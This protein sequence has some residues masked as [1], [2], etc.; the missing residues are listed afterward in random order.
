MKMQSSVWCITC[1]R[2]C[3]TDPGRSVPKQAITHIALRREELC[4]HVRLVHAPVVDR[5]VQRGVDRL[6]RVLVQPQDQ[7]VRLAPVIHQRVG[8]AHGHAVVGER[9]PG[10]PRQRAHPERL[11]VHAVLKHG[12]SLG[13]RARECEAR[14]HALGRQRCG[15]R[16]RQRPLVRPVELPLHR[17]GQRREVIVQARGVK[18]A[19]LRLA[20]QTR[21]HVVLHDLQA[22]PRAVPVRLRGIEEHVRRRVPLLLDEVLAALDQH[23]EQRHPLQ[24]ELRVRRGVALVALAR[25]L[26]IR[27]HPP[28]RLGLQ[29]RV[30][31]RVE[32]DERVVRAVHHAQRAAAP[33]GVLLPGLRRLRRR[34]G[35]PRVPARAL[36]HVLQVYLRRVALR[37]ELRLEDLADP[38]DD[39]G[40][41]RQPGVHQVQERLDLANQHQVEHVLQRGPDL[42]ADPRLVLVRVPRHGL[43]PDRQALPDHAG[44]RVAQ[45]GRLDTQ[46]EAR[47]VHRRQHAVGL[48]G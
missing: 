40:V 48:R 42:V 15:R 20:R 19:G 45:R 30:A 32:H 38:V 5:G 26:Q 22:L 11:V 33:E 46:L 39:P 7:A 35:Q 28:R 34:D 14:V 25:A 12:E 3:Q 6:V 23:V 37:R 36:R 17:R 24:V 16:H 2:A 8:L 41:V 43:V 18:G 29:L 44:R 1:G 27:L 47:G 31:V 13:R 21:R 10:V 4:V 9:A